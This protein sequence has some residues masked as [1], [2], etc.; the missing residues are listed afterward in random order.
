MACAQWHALKACDLLAWI[1]LA[2]QHSDAS[3]LDSLGFCKHRIRSCHS[4]AVGQTGD[5]SAVLHALHMHAQAPCAY[6]GLPPGQHAANRANVMMM[7]APESRRRPAAW[8][9]NSCRTPNSKCAW[10]KRSLL[11]ASAIRASVMCCNRPSGIAP[12]V[13]GP[14]Y[15][16]CTRHTVSLAPELEIIWPSLLHA[17]RTGCTHPHIR[18]CCSKSL[19]AY[20]SRCGSCEA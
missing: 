6:F 5:A 16:A 14:K 15:H 7:P 20:M 4:R 2:R 1:Q 3:M 9:Q 19:Q 18:P 13:D 10:T 11:P 8:L 17:M 12:F